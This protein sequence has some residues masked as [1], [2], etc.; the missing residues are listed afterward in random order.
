VS[1]RLERFELR[2]FGP[3]TD[4]TLELGAPGGGLHIIC[5]P[6]EVGKTTAQ[7]GIGDFLFGIPTRS[8]DDHL[9]SYEDM[10]LAATVI[11]QGGTRHDL[12]RRKGNAR[13]LLGP[14]G[15]PVDDGVLDRM[16]G[17]MTRELFESMFS[18]THESLVVGGQAL[19][20]ADGNLGESLFS[21]SLGASGLHELRGRLDQEAGEL[22]RPRATSSLILQARSA[23]STAQA[24]LADAT[25]RATTFVKHERALKSARKERSEVA[26][27]LRAERSA[28]QRRERL[29]LAI[30]KLA[31]RAD[32]ESE[33]ASLSDA[34]A[35]PDDATERRLL[36]DQSLRTNRKGVED[37]ERRVGE[38][39]DR[40]DGLSPDLRLLEHE[41]AIKG[42]AGRLE[43]VREATTDLERQ[44]AKEHA[45]RAGAQNA[46]TR[47][48]PELDFEQADSLRI[49]EPTRVKVT[50]VLDQHSRLTTRM[51]EAEQAAAE[52]E[53]RALELE[54]KLERAEIPADTSSL[55][56]AVA[57]AASEGK[58]EERLA[59]AE[60]ALE[61][62]E[63]ALQVSVSELSPALL[64][65]SL[66]E[67]TPPDG[68]VISAFGKRAGE[69]ADRERDLG[70]RREEAE[71]RGRELVEEASRLTLDRAVPS[72]EDLVAVRAERD[73]G[74]KQIRA[75]LQDGDGV[76]PDP[77]DFEG[78]VAAADEVADLLCSEAT[79]VAR[80]AQLGVSRE[81]LASELDHLEGNEAALAR[82]CADHERS[83]TELWRS[84]GVETG[85]AA[86]MTQWL[87][88]RSRIVERVSAVQVQRRSIA[89]EQRALE[90]HATALRSALASLGVD[91]EML[92]TLSLS[93][94]LT[95]A[96]GQIEEATGQRE[97]R[98]D[99]ERDLGA[100]RS[101]AR[102]QLGKV[103][104][105]QRELDDWR[106]DWT[107][108]ADSINWR[109]EGGPDD[110]R[111]M[112]ACVVDL[113][114]E[115]REASQVEARVQGIQQRLDAFTTDA[116]ALIAQLQPDL[117]ARPA[118]D[119][120]AELGRCLE[121][122]LETRRQELTL[123]EQLLVA[124]EDA[125][126]ARK[127]AETDEVEIAALIENAG[128]ES[129]DGLP[130]AE[131]RSARAA[132]LRVHL[133]RLEAQIVELGKAPLA[134]LVELCDGVDIDGLDTRC[135]EAEGQITSLEE[136]VHQFDSQIGAMDSEHRQMQSH[137]GASNAAEEVQ[138]RVA[139]L[140]DLAERYLRSYVAAWALR[141][142][143]DAYRLQHKGPLLER[144]E[145][146]FPRLTGGSFR[147]LEVGIDAN[148]EPVLVGVRKNGKRTPVKA[149]S[150]GTREQLYLSL[151]LASLER[152]IDLHGPTPVVLDDVVL[153]SD[154]DRKTAILRA[155]A[156]LGRLTQVIAFTHD[157]QVVALAQ[158]SVHPDLLIVHEFGDG[159]IT[160]ALQSQIA[161]AD[162]RQIH[163]ERAA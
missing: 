144:A 6:N 138:R 20:A 105:R 7:R 57:D 47:I 85:S 78:R 139:D 82:E 15:E 50:E 84:I 19:L 2:A 62:A 128:V 72:A 129:A 157:P 11:D 77:K 43:N 156:E 56:S 89:S 14:S 143:I 63:E 53:D 33:L 145:E 111:S 95:I 8:T 109:I 76:A 68:L 59:K 71:R 39:Q 154:P 75:S 103:A 21:A 94:L 108:L 121:Q 46:L 90:R 133:P 126:T 29:R 152:H 92:P 32:A 31:E 104:D 27:E 100:V 45:F 131:R 24:E 55:S 112:L 87:Q 3:F 30:P 93:G 61:D 136:T 49:T 4:T 142:A 151:R 146:L 58:F 97:S 54:S 98:E 5:G 16:L 23:L 125:E 67:A 66:L 88:A 150:E 12:I 124:R 34:P 107:Q 48:D 101:A 13:T 25:L 123:S 22:F 99:L 116:E 141:Q 158:N 80:H 44:K 42:L 64:L 155:L 135:T 17:G 114:N 132:E 41:Q 73:Q 65:D 18:I 153:H 120:V 96:E 106:T 37:A 52:A 9:H 140:R 35:L 102:K 60:S 119:A 38:L 36:G 149:M 147:G 127:A 28:Q 74:W 26:E 148:D 51:Q 163:A 130:E 118:P 159:E 162:V 1:L 160:R 122:A 91:G 10:R 117:A 113:T 161:Q 115:L 79:S 40:V 69:L 70:R 86:V 134:A 137:G 110:A 81:A 83:W